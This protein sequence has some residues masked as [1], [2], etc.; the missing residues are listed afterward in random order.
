MGPL[1]HDSINTTVCHS[2]SASEPAL[3][4]SRQVCKH[5]YAFSPIYLPDAPALLPLRDLVRGL[6]RRAATAAQYVL[7]VR[8]W[9]AG[10][11]LLSGF[12]A[13]VL[14]S[15]AVRLVKLSQMFLCAWRGL[16]ADVFQDASIAL[17]S[18]S[19]HMGE[20]VGW[21]MCV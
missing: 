16:S 3:L 2:R 7:R 6:G 11:P 13:G 15:G 20:P 1:I 4:V 21:M 14:F 19:E 17:R 8:V 12:R 5:Q 9:D 10:P 18:H